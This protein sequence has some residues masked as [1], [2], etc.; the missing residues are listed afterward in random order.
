MGSP[1]SFTTENQEQPRQ[2]GGASSRG[3]P[4]AATDSVDAP[5]SDEQPSLGPWLGESAPPT[6]VLTGVLG[7]LAFYYGACCLYHRSAQ[8]RGSS[9]T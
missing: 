5:Y 6:G 4:M 3:T 8:R 1:T 9:S 2:Q 7:E